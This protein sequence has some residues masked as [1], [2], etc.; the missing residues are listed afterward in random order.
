M[1]LQTYYQV[2]R[3]GGSG[4]A[5]HLAEVVNAIGLAVV[6]A[7]GAEIPYLAVRVQ[8]RVLLTSGGSGN[9]NHLA[10]IVNAI[11]ITE[12]TAEGAKIPHLALVVEEGVLEAAPL[13]VSE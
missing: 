9:T 3:I 11:G 7:E 10:E 2:S 4:N 8:K 1:H 13:R 5:N 6:S 12:T